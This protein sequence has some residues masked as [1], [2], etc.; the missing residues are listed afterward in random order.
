LLNGDLKLIDSI[1]ERLDACL[2][3]TKK[4]FDIVSEDQNFKEFGYVTYDDIKSITKENVNLIA[5][6]APSG[7]SLE[8]PDP[9]HI[10]RIY[11]E[12]QKVIF[13]I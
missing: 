13:F 10:T 7:T 4:Q 6:K 12:V 8:Q 11:D 5:V 2:E 3:Y 9:D 1:I